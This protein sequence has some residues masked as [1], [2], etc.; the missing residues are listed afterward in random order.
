MNSLPVTPPITNVPPV[1]AIVVRCVACWQNLHPGSPIRLTGR[2][3][4]CPGHAEWTTAEQEAK[5]HT[6]DITPAVTLVADG[7]F[8]VPS[9]HTAIVGWYVLAMVVTWHGAFSGL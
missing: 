9:R 7:A 3:H 5:N 4:F 8:C 6:I 1:S 2:A